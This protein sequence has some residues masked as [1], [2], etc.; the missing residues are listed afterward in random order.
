MV[1]E[2]LRMGTVTVCGEGPADSNSA[3]SQ[4]AASLHRCPGLMYS[5]SITLFSIIRCKNELMGLS[6]LQVAVGTPLIMSL[7]LT[8]WW[9][10]QHMCGY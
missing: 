6:D 5:I 2:T 8:P 9:L 4:M 3:K 7:Q 10:N 1:L